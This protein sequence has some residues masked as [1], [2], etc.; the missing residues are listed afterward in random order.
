MRYLLSFATLL[1]A[2]PL[3]AA[4]PPKGFAPLFDGTN[5][6]GWHGWNIHAKGAGPNDLA[7]LAPDERAKK[8]EE[9]TADAKKH[10][11]VE[12]GE[13]VNDGSGAY[14]ATDK[15]YGDI[16]LLIE[17]KTVAKAD[18]GIYLR[19]TPQVQIWD[20]NQKFD[21]KNP[22]RKPHLVPAG[23]STTPLAQMAAIRSCSRTSR[24]ASGTR[25]AFCKWASAQRCT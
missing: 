23:C 2:F 12:N 19:N 1:L 5:L 4:E 6:D 14:L 15:E 20:S 16:E 24:S 17:Y 3:L 22:D 7:K 8:V 21:P 9:W 18:S 11:S 25:S 10:W 13:L